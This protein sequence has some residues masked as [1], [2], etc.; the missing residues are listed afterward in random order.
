MTKQEGVDPIFSDPMARN[1]E[2]DAVMVA[3]ISNLD[4]ALTADIASVAQIEGVASIL[5]VVCRTTGMG[6]AAVA[7]VTEDRWVACAVRDEIAFG[8]LPGG[9]LNVKTT[10][11]DEIRANG[12]AVIIDH[13]AKDESYQGHHTPAMYGFQSYISIPILL[14]N[15]SMFGTLC[16]PSTRGLLNSTDPKSSGCSRTSPS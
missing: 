14:P 16:A 7:R 10:I 2:V 8:L 1:G 9:E 3:P 5:E 4:A 11:C 12:R 13:V 6:F 15:G